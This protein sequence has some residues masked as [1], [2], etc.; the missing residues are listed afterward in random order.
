[1]HHGHT[2]LGLVAR[3]ITRKRTS[4]YMHVAPVAPAAPNE[5]GAAAACAAAAGASKTE[6]VLAVE[7]LVREAE[8]GAPHV[9]VFILLY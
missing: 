7:V 3:I 2:L 6:G 4:R 9:S 5:K 1:M 8:A